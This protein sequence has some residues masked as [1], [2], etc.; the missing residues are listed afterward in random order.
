M[1]EARYRIREFENDDYPAQA[2]LNNRV[3]PDELRT[4]EELQHWAE[5]IAAPHLIRRR[6][7]VEERG[8]GAVVAS[9]ELA[10]LPFNYHPKKFWTTVQV[11]PDYRRQGI[12]QSLYGLLEREAVERAAIGLWG[13]AR[14][15]DLAGIG[16]LQRQGFVEQRRLWI[17]R[18]ELARADLS[19][20]PERSAILAAEGIRFSTLADEGP[21]RPEVRERL[22]RVWDASGADVP[23]VGTHAS[24]PFDLFTRLTLEGPNFRAGAVFLAIHDDEYVGVTVNHGSSGDP[25]TLWVGFTGTLRAYRG[26]GIASELKRRAIEYARAQGYRYMRTGNDSLNAPI[27]AINERLGFTRLRTW[28]QAEK[29]LSGAR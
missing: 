11:D 25:E 3:D 20:L 6:F 2:R 24:V 14:L 19:A 18:L 29:A 27:W 10:Q 17:S 5:S 15:D 21:D 4:A 16:F 28:V 7:V 12:G 23:T 9:G 13:S 22:H 26:R 1:D 8:S